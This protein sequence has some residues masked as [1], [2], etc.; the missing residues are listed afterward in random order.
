[1]YHGMHVEVRGQFVDVDYPLITC[2]FQ[3]LMWWWVPLPAEP[4]HH[5]L[6]C[7][8][9][10][11]VLLRLFFNWQF[12]SFSLSNAGTTVVCHKPLLE[13]FITVVL[14][15]CVSTLWRVEQPFHRGHLSDILHIR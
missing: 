15:L 1:M 3:G 12:S 10:L 7:L 8:Y 13:K 9:L 11:A 5:H 2:G 6:P 4:F 14:N